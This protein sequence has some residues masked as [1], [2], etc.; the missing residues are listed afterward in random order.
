MFTRCYVSASNTFNTNRQVKYRK[1]YETPK[2]TTS[3]DQAKVKQ[4]P[5]RSPVPAEEHEGSENNSVFP[6]LLSDIIGNESLLSTFRTR[7]YDVK[8]LTELIM[9]PPLIFID[10]GRQLLWYRGIPIQLWPASFSYL[11]LLAKRPKEMLKREEIYHHLWPG[12]MNYSGANKP[13][14]RQ[15]SDHKRKLIAQIRKGMTGKGE[16]GPRELETLIFTRP[17]LGYMLNV[18]KENVFILP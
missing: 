1:E 10:E 9:N 16:I 11:L 8:N 4:E 12:E 6:C 7:L 17:K 3:D 15:I 13:Y 5:G 14:E 2:E 18:N